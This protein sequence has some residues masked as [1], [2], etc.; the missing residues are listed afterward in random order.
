M[1][2]NPFPRRGADGKPA[3]ALWL[4]VLMAEEIAEATAAAAAFTAETL[5]EDKV[6][7]IAAENIYQD[8]KTIEVLFRAAKRD[9][10][11]ATAFFPSPAE[12]RAHMTAD[13]LAVLFHEYLDLQASLG[14]IVG[15][16]SRQEM[17]AVID[18][19]AEGGQAFPLGSWSWEARTALMKHMAYRLRA[20]STGTSSPGGPPA[21]RSAKAERPRA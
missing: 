4:T 18:R 2:T 21:K 7:E 15:E 10:K 8:A 5:G 14:P 19:L 3:C 16:M 1:A 11:L 9:K 17:D 13:E 20:S 12:M 6:L